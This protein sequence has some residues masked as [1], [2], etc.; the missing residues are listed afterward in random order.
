MRI[1]GV[2]VS[3]RPYQVFC[4]V[5]RFTATHWTPSLRGHGSSWQRE[6]PWCQ[7]CEGA[8]HT[9]STA[10]AQREVDSGAQ[11]ASPTFPFHPV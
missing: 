9:V 2:P 1:A 3:A 6:K 5:A 11:P 4:L 10:R 8:G 7:G